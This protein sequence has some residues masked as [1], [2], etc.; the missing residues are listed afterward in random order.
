MTTNPV[1]NNGKTVVQH[2]RIK[3]LHQHYQ[4]QTLDRKRTLT[5]I[6]R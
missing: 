4:I 1:I 2:N 3:V 5:V 6:A